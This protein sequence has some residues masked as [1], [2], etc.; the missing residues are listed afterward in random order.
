MIGNASVGKTSIISR[1]M[2]DSMPSSKKPTIGALE[3]NKT[4]FL[5]ASSRNLNV[6]V[7]DVSGQEKFRSIANMY[8]R[9]ADGA[10]LIYDTTDRKT[11]EDVEIWLGELN[12]K[13]PKSIEIMMIGNKIDL[14]DKE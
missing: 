2:Y 13:A 12:E 11:F 4:Y 7:W 3:H 9:D 14:T 10:L 6:C 5:E 1:F 8:Y